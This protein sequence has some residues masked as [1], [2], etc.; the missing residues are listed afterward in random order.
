[1]RVGSG[2]RAARERTERERKV[3][4]GRAPPLP[5]S[6]TSPAV[7]T[8]ASLW[9]ANVSVAQSCRRHAFIT[10]I[11]SGGL[12][13]AAFIHFVGQ[14]AV[15]LRAFARA[16]AMAVAKAPDTASMLAF[17]ELLDG[18]FSELDL[19]RSYAL[20]W[21]ADLDPEPTPAAL[22]YTDFLQRVAGFEPIA[23]LCAAMAPCMRLY[24]WLG[25]EIAPTTAADTPY[26]EWVDTYAS[27]EADD[28]ATALERMLDTFGGDPEQLAE[29]YGR[30]MRL[31]LDFFDS[32]VNANG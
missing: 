7:K 9:A 4:V 20:R 13:R 26:R 27:D 30:A 22:A 11:E 31:E 3:C 6:R 15:F 5:S 16:Y 18:V 21:G 12:D 1:M 17:K 28:L 23:N 2:T 32:A 24:A 19:H 25:R 10:G 29:R 14:D 8:S